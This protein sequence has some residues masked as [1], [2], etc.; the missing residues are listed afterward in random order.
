MRDFRPISLIGS[1]YKILS[2]VLPNRLTK[3]LPD[4][5]SDNQS[6]FVNGRQILDSVVAAHELSDS[7]HKQN[8]PGVLC[9]LDFE[10]ACDMVD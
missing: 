4:V 2:K 1:I 6:A 10:K 7:R 3:M 5:I 8:R 9:K